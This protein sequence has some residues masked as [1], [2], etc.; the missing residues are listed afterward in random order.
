MMVFSSIKSFDR[1]NRGKNIVCKVKHDN[2]DLLIYSK[3]QRTEDQ[4]NKLYIWYI[5]RDEPPLNP[6]L[7]L[8]C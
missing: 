8:D 5:T 1:R 3:Y 6:A 2:N 4:T 7:K